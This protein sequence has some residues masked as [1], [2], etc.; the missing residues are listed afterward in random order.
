MDDPQ[1]PLSLH[2][3]S[4][5]HLACC[6]WLPQPEDGMDQAKWAIPR[7]RDCLST[8]EAQGLVRP[9]LKLH[10][11]WLHN[12][13][14]NIF[15]VHPGIAADSSLILECLARVLER[16]SAEF[17]A[18]GKQLPEALFLW[19]PWPVLQKIFGQSQSSFRCLMSLAALPGR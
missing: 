2:M 4:G 1:C 15:L 14:L 10:A 18:Q 17:N 11:V 3:V 5:Q 6:L 8:K 9:R 13:S 19:D 7:Q 16:T 12:I